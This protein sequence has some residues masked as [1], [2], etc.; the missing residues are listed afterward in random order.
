MPKRGQ[1][2]RLLVWLDMISQLGASLDGTNPKSWY[3]NPQ[4]LLEFITRRELIIKY[5]AKVAKGFPPPRHTVC[6][7]R[8]ERHYACDLWE[9]LPS[10]QKSD[11]EPRFIFWSL[12]IFLRID[13]ELLLIDGRRRLGSLVRAGLANRHI[14]VWVIEYELERE[15]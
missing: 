3:G 8:M 9:T 6:S 14:T 2:Q 13:G 4:A 11:R 5:G 15:H 10:H 7:L 12:P 1:K